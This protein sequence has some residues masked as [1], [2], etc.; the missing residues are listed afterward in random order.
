[1]DFRDNPQKTSIK[2][3]KSG[4]VKYK[5]V[6]KCPSDF[7]KII[8]LVNSLPNDLDLIYSE[9]KK[10]FD[11]KKKSLAERQHI[12]RRASF[13]LVFLPDKY[14]KKIEQLFPEN[15]YLYVIGIFE[16]DFDE[17]IFEHGT[18]AQ[19]KPLEKLFELINLRNLLTQIAKLTM[20]EFNVGHTSTRLTFQ[21][22]ISFG[23]DKNE[24][25]KP[26]AN[27]I[28]EIFERNNLSLKRIRQCP[29]CKDI[30]WAN[31]I[32]APTCI[33]KR[34]SNNFNKKKSRFREDEERLDKELK[35]LEKWQLDLSPKNSLIHQQKKKV[36][37]LKIKVEKNKITLETDLETK[38]RHFDSKKLKEIKEKNNVIV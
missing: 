27:P 16:T 13:D 12:D 17:L 25:V 10:D 35:T 23:L 18:F 32:D 2:S 30:F 15:I 21:P 22:L 33:E 9:L 5:E 19:L 31:R 36:E 1:M 11:N 37:K 20:R 3:D 34:C 8:E 14:G 26:F 6:V 7:N 28:V 29:I 38:R 24:C 4:K